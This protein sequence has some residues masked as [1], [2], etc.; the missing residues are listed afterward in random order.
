MLVLL[1]LSAAFD[2][3]DHEILLKRLLGWCGI[4]GTVLKWFQ[5]YLKERTQTVM[6][7]FHCAK[8]TAECTWIDH[9]G[10][11]G[12]SFLVILAMTMT[13]TINLN[14]FLLV[15][16]AS[17]G[18]YESFEHVQNFCAPRTNNFHSCLC[19]LKTCSYRLFRTAC[20][21]Y[22]SRSYCILIVL[23]VY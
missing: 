10:L 13:I 7:Q 22:S 1:D 15:R 16:V 9:S 12:W 19:A 4:N 20:V 23:T 8:C 18:Q 6:P 14:S 21:L 2:T 5:S 3:I 17:A 11:F